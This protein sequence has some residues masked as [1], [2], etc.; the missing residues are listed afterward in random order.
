MT[1][2]DVFNISRNIDFSHEIFNVHK[3]YMQSVL[4]EVFGGKGVIH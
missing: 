1:I 2:T 3:Y 4:W